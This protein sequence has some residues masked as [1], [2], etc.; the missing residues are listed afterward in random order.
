MKNLCYFIIKMFDKIT[1]IWNDR[2]YEIIIIVSLCLILVLA[3]FRIGK[4]GTWSDSY[5]LDVY[6]KPLIFTNKKQKKISKGESE[7]R[8]VLR[9]IFNKPFDT[10]RPNFLRNPVTSSNSDLGDNFNLELDCFESVLKLACEYQGEQHYRFIPYFHK[11]KEA[12]RNQQ[13]RDEL[14]RR[15]CRDNGINLIEVP[16]TVKLQNIESYIIEQLKIIGYYK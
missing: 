8:R 9:K 7:C 16:H 3:L 4:K 5:N 13:Y 2:G 1:N 10:C 6:N 14:K 11:N 12:F 15:M